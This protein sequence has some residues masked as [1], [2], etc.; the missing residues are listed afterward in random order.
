MRTSWATWILIQTPWKQNEDGTYSCL[1]EAGGCGASSFSPGLGTTCDCST[2]GLSA[3]EARNPG[4]SAGTPAASHAEGPVVEHLTGDEILE[5]ATRGRLPSAEEVEQVMW[6]TLAAQRKLRKAIQK[7]RTE[8]A[9]EINERGGIR[10]RQAWLAKHSK[11]RLRIQELDGERKTVE[12]LYAW[13]NERRQ[14]ELVRQDNETARILHGDESPRAR[15]A[16]AN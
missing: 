7:A 13:A 16:E 6:A 9:E 2:T 12:T 11:L 15:T 4:D 8:D 14:A 3:Q 5:R 1:T 10:W